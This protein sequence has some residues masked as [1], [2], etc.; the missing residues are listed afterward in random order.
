MCCR[1]LKKE[2]AARDSRNV[3]GLGS[4][5]L[6]EEFLKSCGRLSIVEFGEV[7]G[8]RRHSKNPSPEGEVAG[9]VAG[10]KFRNDSDVKSEA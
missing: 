7:F 3:K 9:V 6:V 1:R 4:R 8:K 5:A 2:M 10:W